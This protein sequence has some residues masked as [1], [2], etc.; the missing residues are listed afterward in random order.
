[1]TLGKTNFNLFFIFLV[2]TF[3]LVFVSAFNFEGDNAVFKSYNITNTYNNV[4]GGTSNV[5]NPMTVD[6]NM[7]GNQIRNVSYINPVGRTLNIA[8]LVNVENLNVTG[9]FTRNGFYGGMYST[10]S[11]DTGGLT[12]I[13][14]NATYQIINFSSSPDTMF[15]FVFTNSGGGTETNTLRLTNEIAAGMY[16]VSW[17]TVKSG[18][19]HVIDGYVYVNEVRQNNTYTIMKTGAALDI[20]EMSSF[21]LIR[22]NYLDNITLR[23]A[24]K[25]SSGSHTIYQKNLALFR[26]GN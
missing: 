14:L 19:T 17:R 9:N 12:G 7:S 4:S 16:Q 26:V 1:M 5:T 25:T 10:N 15:G 2:F 8:G 20:M 18:S 23:I 6:L 24:D 3:S 11:Y 13:I 21:A 22:V